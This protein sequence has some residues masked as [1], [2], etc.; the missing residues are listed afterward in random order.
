MKLLLILLL[1][2]QPVFAQSMDDIN[3]GIRE[4][5]AAQQRRESVE[6]KERLRAEA[7]KPALT[8]WQRMAE[9][10]E[11]ALH[12]I[13]TIERWIGRLETESII[14]TLRVEGQ[15]E[16]IYRRMD[17]ENELS[18]L[19]QS[20]YKLRLA[21]IEIEAELRR[22]AAGLGDQHIDF[23]CITSPFAKECQ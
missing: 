5:A 10:R 16:R 19:H 22:H 13:S 14:G 23:T 21:V 6:E 8:K 17:R 15:S 3:R 9:Q 11:E 1:V 2:C 4:R 20:E 12:T 7:A 18:D